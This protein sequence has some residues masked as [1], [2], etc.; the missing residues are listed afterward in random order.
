[1]PGLQDREAGVQCIAL[2]SYKFQ[3]CWPEPLSRRAR[4]PDQDN[5]FVASPSDEGEPAEVLVL[6][7]EDAPLACG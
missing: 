6:G 2:R 1:M 7:E 5:S 4:E 3:D